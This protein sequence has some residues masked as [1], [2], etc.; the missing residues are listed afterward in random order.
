MSA[1]A[2]LAAF[3]LALAATFGV[4]FGVGAVTAPDDG[5]HPSTSTHQMP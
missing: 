2:K 4:G 5:P 1:G 3:A